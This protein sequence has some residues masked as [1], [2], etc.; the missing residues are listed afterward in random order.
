M[1][2]TLMLQMNH[3]PYN[4]T[5][6]HLSKRDKNITTQTKENEFN[7]CDRKIVSLHPVSSLLLPFPVYT[8]V[9]Q[10]PRE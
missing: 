1:I 7:T 8:F 4:L 6:G 2:L 3:V 9:Q 10:Q 5:P